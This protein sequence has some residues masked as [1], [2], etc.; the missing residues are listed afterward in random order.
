MEPVFVD[1]EQELAFFNSILTRDYPPSGQLVL[2]YGRRRIGKTLLV[3]HWAE[4][5]GLPTIYWAAENE[6]AAMQR[7]QL[8]A[9]MTDVSM[10][11]AP[12]FESW[13][14][15]WTAFTKL[16]GNR[17]Q[18][19]ILDEVPYAAEADVGHSV[20]HFP[21]CLCGEACRVVWG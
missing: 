1:R 3:R 4:A 16:V 18:I 20:R 19:L 6:P 2:L 9:R 8:F 14:D 15:L 17:R 13:T 21:L 11:Q 7:R 10:A 12:T 5:S